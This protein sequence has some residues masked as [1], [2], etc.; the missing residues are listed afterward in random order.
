[1]FV[2]EST[3]S[4]T[5]YLRYV[6][7]PQEEEAGLV[8]VGITN[9]WEFSWSCFQSCCESGALLVVECFHTVRKAT[10]PGVTG[11]T[12]CLPAIRT[13][14]PL[15]WALRKF[16][17]VFLLLLSGN[18]RLSLSESETRDLTF[19]I[20]AVCL[21]CLVSRLSPP[22]AR[23]LHWPRFLQVMT[24]LRCTD[25]P[26]ITCSCWQRSKQSTVV[27]CLQIF[28]HFENELKHVKHQQMKTGCVCL[29][30]GV[31]VET[32]G[33][34]RFVS[35]DSA[36]RFLMTF[37]SAGLSSDKDNEEEQ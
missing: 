28:S 33:G 30:T 7:V 25:S 14:A 34:G 22:S 18:L 27:W 3:F 36:Q 6:Q 15:V 21:I 29:L 23:C 24:S 31:A 10:T 1:M 35:A 11:C 4:K 9:R 13:A 12:G 20:P 16:C 37:I 26:P 5:L 19:D 2:K 32:G 8:T 17:T